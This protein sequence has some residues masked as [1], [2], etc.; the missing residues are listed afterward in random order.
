MKLLCII[1]ILTLTALALAESW[2]LPEPPLEFDIDTTYIP[3]DCTVLS[4]EGDDIRVHVVG[5]VL[6]TGKIF[7]SRSVL[8]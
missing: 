1:S 6:E 5:T 3:E 7:S 4:A 2:L 8:G